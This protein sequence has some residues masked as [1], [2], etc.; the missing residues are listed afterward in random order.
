MYAYH[1]VLI[2]TSS[3]VEVVRINTN[4]YAKDYTFGV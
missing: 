3:R 1:H 4:E 2:F